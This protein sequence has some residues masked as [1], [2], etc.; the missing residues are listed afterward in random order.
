MT[1]KF[2][3]AKHWQLFALTFGIPLIFQLFMIGSVITDIAVH[4]NPDPA[5]MFNFMKFFPVIMILYLVVFFGW[6][7]S[8][9]IGLQNKVPE[10]VTM[11][12]NFLF[13][14]FCG[15]NF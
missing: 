9:A 11:K 14:L 4:E 13:P 12:S 15:Q 8:V 6:H 10:N 7:W 1:D 3:K 2:L 5:M